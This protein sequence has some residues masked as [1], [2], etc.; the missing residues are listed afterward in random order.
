MKITR[1]VAEILSGQVGIALKMRGKPMTKAEVK[2]MTAGVIGANDWA[3]LM[4][5]IDAAG[6]T[7]EFDFKV[8][9]MRENLLTVL[10]QKTA[11]GQAGVE[12]PPPVA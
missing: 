9:K 1:R 10:R 3:D 4:A 7:I 5:R 6:G 2:D 11:G 12:T 8:G